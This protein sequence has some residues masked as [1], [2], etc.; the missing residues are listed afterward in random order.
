[1]DVDIELYPE[2]VRD[3][4]EDAIKQSVDGYINKE[5]REN[6]LECPECG[7]TSSFDSQVESDGNG[8]YNE[9]AICAGCGEE[10]DVEV[11]I[12]DLR[13]GF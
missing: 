4:L 7:E 12:G 10:V 3:K 2:P 13:S 6:N 11:K 5:I 9:S 1:M 8:N